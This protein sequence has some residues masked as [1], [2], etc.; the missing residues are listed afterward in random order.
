MKDAVQLS[1]F[2]GLSIVMIALSIFFMCIQDDPSKKEEETYK[3]ITSSIPV[4]RMSFMLIF[5]IFGAALN[6]QVFTKVGINYLF[7]LELDPHHKMTHHTLYR[8]AAFLFF[9]WS[10]CFTLTLA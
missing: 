1:L 5:V 9:I 8:V 4:L 2:G 10:T 6:V 3:L 7:I